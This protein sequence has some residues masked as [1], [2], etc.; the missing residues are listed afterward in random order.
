MDII[1]A[2]KDSDLKKQIQSKIPQPFK[3]EPHQE[4]NSPKLQDSP[5]EE[6]IDVFKLF[7][8]LFKWK[9]LILGMICFS[10][11]AASLGSFLLNEKKY[12]S[13]IA[14]ALNFPGIEKYL[15][16]D[17]STFNAKQLIT[18]HILGKVGIPNRVDESRSSNVQLSNLIE[19]K[20]VIANEIQKKIDDAKEKGEVYEFFPNQ[21]LISLITDDDTLI[22]NSDRETVLN[23]IVNQYKQDAKNKFFNQDSFFEDY[24]Y[25]F[26]S[27]NDYLEN[28]K[29][30]NARVNAL[31]KFID[32]NAEKT[33]D[34]RSPETNQ[35]FVDLKYQLELF[36]DID[37][38][39]IEAFVKNIY[40]IKNVDMYLSKLNFK[41]KELEEN[42]AKET[43]KTSIAKEL[44]K[45]INSQTGNQNKSANSQSNVMLETSSFIN[46][47]RTEDDQSYLIKIILESETSAIDFEVDKKR[48]VDNLAN[49][50]QK[51]KLGTKKI[52][53][54]VGNYLKNVLFPEFKQ[55]NDQLKTL[56]AEF[57]ISEKANFIKIIQIPLHYEI[58][59][60][61][62]SIKIL[63]IAVA[64]ALFLSVF[65]IFIIES[66]RKI[67]RIYK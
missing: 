5:F 2:P 42:K 48:I 49:L 44:L 27:S 23:S 58:D 38:K 67:E 21:F 46:K 18:P 40:L 59:S 28:I 4:G 31:I 26:N 65:L 47:L 53:E 51:T 14:V 41:I 22:P 56:N 24:S 9:Y 35:T 13:D 43:G 17:G 1:K 16:P 11:A 32:D 50:S 20:S 39:K 12:V 61:S 52:H 54:Y 63:A 66:I 15:N 25:D 29:I 19:V 33:N 8:V 37:V 45:E 30:I 36:Q 55:L 64:I 3:P 10:I 62:I 6:E 57:Q 7:M 60:H 34:F